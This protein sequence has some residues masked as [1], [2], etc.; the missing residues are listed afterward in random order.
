M[1]HLDGAAGRAPD[2]FRPAVALGEPEVADLQRRLHGDVE[3]GDFGAMGGLAKAITGL[4]GEPALVK[5]ASTWPW[6]SK[7]LRGFLTAYAHSRSPTRLA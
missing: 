5:G 4:S 2:A 1:H 7:T 3:G 6:Q